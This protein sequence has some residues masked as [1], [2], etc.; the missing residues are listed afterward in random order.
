MQCPVPP[1]AAPWPIPPTPEV[2][3]RHSGWLHDRTRVRQAIYGEF[4][5][6]P[7]LDRFDNCGANAWVIRRDDDPTV[8]AIV[9]DHCHDRFCRPCASFKGRVIA[10][11]IKAVIGTRQFRF[12]TLTIKTTDLTLKQG[13]DKLYRSFGALRRTKLWKQ[14]VDGGCAVCEVKPRGSGAG[15]HPHLHLVLQGR[16]LPQRALS[17]VWFRITRDSYIVDVRMGKR[18]DDAASYVAKYI[19]KPFHSDLIRQPHRLTEA[20]QALHGRRMCL[21]FGDWRG[22]KLCEYA[23]SGTWT[24]IAPLSTL[25]ETAAAGDPDACEML[26]YLERTQP[27]RNLPKPNIRGSPACSPGQRSFAWTSSPSVPCAASDSNPPF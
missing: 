27:W 14:R 25:L 22:V 8:V 5:Y 24:A 10:N 9:S 21:T 2:A 20:V 16:F 13:V 3:F 4:G 23:P 19:G 18:A 1:Q 7:R 6:G 12:V 15:W 26:H 11:N 17:N